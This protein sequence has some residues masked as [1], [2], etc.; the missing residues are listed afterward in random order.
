[1]TA[2]DLLLAWE[3]WRFTHSS[4]DLNEAVDEFLHKHGPKRTSEQITFQMAVG[5]SANAILRTCERLDE[6]RRALEVEARYM[7]AMHQ[8]LA[9][10]YPVGNAAVPA[11]AKPEV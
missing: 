5:E 8:E 7:R 11:D 2:V 10:L 4:L 9:R 6:Y 1:M 3:E